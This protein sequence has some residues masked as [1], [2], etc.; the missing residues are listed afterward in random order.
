MKRFR[1]ASLC[2]VVAFLAMGAAI[3]VQE[4]KIARLEREAR[5]RPPLLLL[6]G[7]S[8]FDPVPNPARS[9]NPPPKVLDPQ[10]VVAAPLATVDA[11]LKTL[12]PP[13]VTLPTPSMPESLPIEDRIRALD[14][15]IEGLTRQ[16]DGLNRKLKPGS[17]QPG[18]GRGG[19]P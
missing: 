8:P 15:Q 1:L 4:R 19:R 14:E 17:A 11:Q 7:V 18:S 16:R 10:P 13:S 5:T 12:R 3:V 9:P 2:I 6:P